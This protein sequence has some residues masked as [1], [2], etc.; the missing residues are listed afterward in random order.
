MGL[1]KNCDNVFYLTGRYIALIEHSNNKKMS[2]TQMDN[3]FSH[4]SMFINSYDFNKRNCIEMREEIL[5]KLPSEGF[6]K[7]VNTEESGRMWIGYYHQHATLPEVTIEHHVPT[8]VEC[9]SVN[10]IISELHK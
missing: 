7:R 1:D 3:L 5:S 8:K 4:P 9:S 2:G 10:N 6:P